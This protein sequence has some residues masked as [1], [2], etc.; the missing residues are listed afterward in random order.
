M[1][2][3]VKQ[4]MHFEVDDEACDKVIPGSWTLQTVQDLIDRE[5]VLEKQKPISIAAEDE[6][7]M[8]GKCPCCEQSVPKFTY[9]VEPTKFCGNCGQAIAWIDT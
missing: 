2:K 4:W 7:G 5:I 1:K 8:F 3:N 6:S 9:M